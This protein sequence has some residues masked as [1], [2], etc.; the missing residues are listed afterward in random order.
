M[1]P[2]EI[3]AGDSIEFTE[4]QPEYLATDGWQLRLIFINAS[5]KISLLSSASGGDHK[6]T[7][8]SALTAVW[9]AGNYQTI[10]IAEKSPLRSTLSQGAIVIHPDPVAAVSQDYRTQSQKTLDSLRAAYD[11]MIAGGGSTVQQVSINGRLTV[12]RSAEDIL[13]QINFFQ[14]QVN[15]EQTAKNLQDGCGFGTKILT[16]L[17]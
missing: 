12:F 17:A 13:Q 5:T 4:S 16:R 2:S 11:A 6:F 1:I 9:P 8:N 7:A 3:I 14:R 10:L 15:S